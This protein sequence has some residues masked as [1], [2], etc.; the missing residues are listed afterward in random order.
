MVVQN[1]LLSRA[2]ITSVTQ[3]LRQHGF[4]GVDVSWLFPPPDHREAFQL[5]IA[6]ATGTWFVD[7]FLLMTYDLW[8]FPLPKLGHHTALYLRPSQV[9]SDPPL[10]RLSV[11]QTVSAWLEQGVSRNQLVLGLA[12]F[13]KTTRL[14]DPSSHNLGDT[15]PIVTA[16]P[17]PYTKDGT[18]LAYDEICQYLREP[19]KAWN[20][21]YDA[22]VQGAIAFENRSPYDWVCYDDPQGIR[23]KT[24][25]ALQRDLA[26]V[27]LW[28]MNYD[29]FS[30]SACAHGR[31]PLLS[32][33][34]EVFDS[35]PSPTTTTTTPYRV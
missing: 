19:A 10:S 14:N 35:Q 7:Y 26:G 2:F 15:H 34:K 29:D 12:A 23:A 5:F 21:T 13:G 4:D 33:V 31:F 11:N 24:E 28:I 25:Y 3:Y 32:A 30:G 9:P 6:S 1:P 17:G 18:L 20:Q 22:E 27:F 8:S 16:T